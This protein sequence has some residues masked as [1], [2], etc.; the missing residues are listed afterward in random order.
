[1]GILNKVSTTLDEVAGILFELAEDVKKS[2]SSSI[3]EESLSD[4]ADLATAFDNSDD[5]KLHKLASV[6]DELLLTISTRKGAVEAI[7]NAEDKEIDKLREKYRNQSLEDSYKKKS[8][9][10]EEEAIKE[11]EKK[12]KNYKP[13]EHALSTRY[14]PDMPGVS[15]ARIGDNVYQCP[16]TKKI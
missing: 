1:A 10:Y 15:L 13:M 11:I 4:L 12:V 7:K 3:E 9:E 5:P 8:Y 6:L 16:I 2:S 14:S